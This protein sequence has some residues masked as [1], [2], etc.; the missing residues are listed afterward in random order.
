MT[1]IRRHRISVV[2]LSSS[3]GGSLTFLS[4]I[5]DIIF[6]HLAKGTGGLGAESAKHLAKH[7]ASN[8]YISGRNRQNAEKV[9]TS[10][11]ESGSKTNVIFIECNLAS[12]DS[13]KRAAETF[14]EQAADGLDV[15]M[16]AAGIMAV[17]PGLT[18]DGYEIQFGTNHL[19]HALLIKKL[20]PLLRAR[21]TEG[22]DPRIVILT[23]QAWAGHPRGGVAFEKLR[24][25]QES[26]FMGTWFRY[27]Q[28]KFANLVYARELA[29]RYP[30]ITSVSIHP[31]VVLTDLVGTLRPQ[32]K[33]FTYA[34]TW[35][36]ML[37]PH[38]GAYNQVWAATADKKTLVQGGY[39]EP[40][41]KLENKSLDSTAKNE[42]VGERLWEWT[43]AALE[44]Y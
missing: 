15:L 9:I 11:R 5:Q 16:C 37:Q 18:S 41:G 13:V 10:I 29:K 24:T 20:L 30:E 23:S 19:G 6:L 44:E 22:K 27:G 34:T 43:Q 14:I 40:V 8:I 21:A 42:K 1:L 32:H 36:R 2:N 25:T 3:Q 28:S 4:T 26:F 31:G 17:P 39:Y 7:N 38:E 12:L 35:W 33:A